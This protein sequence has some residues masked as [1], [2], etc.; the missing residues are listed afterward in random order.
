M[1]PTLTEQFTGIEKEPPVKEKARWIVWKS[2]Q[3]PHLTPQEIER[4]WMWRHLEQEQ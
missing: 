2:L 4:E 3:C 1:R